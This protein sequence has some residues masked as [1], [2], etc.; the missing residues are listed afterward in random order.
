MKKIESKLESLKEFK[1]TIEQEI[2]VNGG[3][4]PGVTEICTQYCASQY[5]CAKDDGS[6]DYPT[7]SSADNC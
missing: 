3:G 7:S 4:A 2:S 1:L 6:G 5:D